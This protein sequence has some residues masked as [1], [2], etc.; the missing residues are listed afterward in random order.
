MPKY[1]S[2]K[3]ESSSTVSVFHRSLKE[4]YIQ[5]QIEKIFPSKEVVKTIRFDKSGRFLHVDFIKKDDADTFVYELNGK[6]YSG[7]RFKVSHTVKISSVL[8]KEENGSGGSQI[9]AN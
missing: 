8:T 2:P 4:D 3:Q 1:I 7:A 9:E 5:Y 6:V